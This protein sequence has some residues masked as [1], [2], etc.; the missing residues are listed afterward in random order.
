MSAVPAGPSAGPA[1]AAP[2]RA[3]WLQFAPRERL[4]LS[5]MGWA[6][7]VF[8]AWMMLISPALKTLREAPAKQLAADAQL[9]EMRR[10]A[11][12]ARGLGQQPRLPPAQAEAALNAAVKRLGDKARLQ[13]QGDRATVTLQGIPG[14]EFTAFLAEIRAGA[15]ARPLQA[16]LVR[17]A[18]QGYNGTLVLALAVGL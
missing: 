17:D 5:V 2:L 9:D 8:V 4:A 1:W 11:D 18:A 14:A 16:Q 10:L 12:E 6:V 3:R 7:G 15:R 13:M